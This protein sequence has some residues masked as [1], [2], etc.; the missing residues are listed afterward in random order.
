[1]NKNMKIGKKMKM[2]KMKT[3]MKVKISKDKD[4]HRGIKDK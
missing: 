4:E 3:M 1:M 2:T